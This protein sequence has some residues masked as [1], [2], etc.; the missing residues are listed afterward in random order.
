MKFIDSLELRPR[1]MGKLARIRKLLRKMIPK[2][3]DG[4]TIEIMCRNKKTANE[5]LS[6][7]TQDIMK[8]H[9]KILNDLM[10]TTSGLHRVLYDQIQPKVIR[11]SKAPN[12]PSS[13][14]DD[15]I[16]ETW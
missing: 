7:I 12:E 3:K 4:E 2:M 11:N 1:G 6:Q 14:V 13:P 8:D 9:A 15:H 16:V 5:M 10:S